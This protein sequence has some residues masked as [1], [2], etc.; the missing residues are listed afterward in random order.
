MKWSLLANRCAVSEPLISDIIPSL[1]RSL[2]LWRIVG[3]AVGALGSKVP[4]PPNKSLVCPAKS[5]STSRWKS[6][7]GNYQGV[8]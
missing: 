4:T 2:S 3:G 5:S 7:R 6:G 1:L 8:K